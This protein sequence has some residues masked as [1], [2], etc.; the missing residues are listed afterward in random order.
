MAQAYALAVSA[1]FGSSL[2]RD[3]LFFEWRILNRFDLLE[4]VSVP[5]S[6]SARII[7][8]DVLYPLLPP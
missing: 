5:F 3:A 7:G 6:A 4:F 2:D 8:A 1:S